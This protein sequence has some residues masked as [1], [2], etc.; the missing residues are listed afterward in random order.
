MQPGLAVL[1][2]NR[3]KN[4]GLIESQVLSLSYG[5]VVVKPVEKQRGLVPDS[6]EGYQILGPG[7]IVV[8]PTDLQNDQTSIRVGH[9]K[10][11]GIITSAYIGLR[12]T[13]A[14]G[15][16]YA[17]LYLTVVDSSKRIYG[18][19]SGLRQQLGWSDLKRMPCLV[20][21]A[22]EQAAIV[23]YLAHANTRIDNAIAA[24]RRLI[25]LLHEQRAR[26]TNDLVTGRD[27]PLQSVSSLPWLESVP[28]G[29]EWRRCRTITRFVTSGSRGWAEYYA[30][31]GPIFLQSG[32]LG[33]QLNLKLSNLQRVDL[34][35]SAAEGVR[36][37]VQPR[38]LLMCITGALTGNVSMVPADWTAEAYVNQHIALIRPTH[39]AVDAEF[40][41]LAMKSLP[42]QIQLRASEY[43][44]TKQGLGLAEVKNLEILMPPLAEQRTV[45]ARVADHTARLDRAIESNGNEISLLREFRTRLVADVVTGQVDV[46]AIAATM[47]DAP[48]SF[49]NAVAAIDDDLEEA[50]SEGEE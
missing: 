24:K 20:P 31:Q 26:I 37:R 41:G 1:Q 22:E 50:L 14:W 46:R 3:H 44:G 34:P 5:K 6:Y 12:P 4:D 18:M 8:R 30:A 7:D 40:L 10:D 17:Y 42:S 27:K 35:E 43:G 33:R 47:P 9:V 39:D 29:W 23:K 25:K 16:S 32:N 45:I 19:G 11:R 38:D 15:D 28:E 49:D 48:E 2:E 36:T 21:P 13:G